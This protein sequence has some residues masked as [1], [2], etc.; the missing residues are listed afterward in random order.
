MTKGAEKKAV[1]RLEDVRLRFG[2]VEALRG[3]SLEVREGEILA[4]IGP[5]GAGKTCVFNCING[6]YKPHAG[7]IYYGDVEITKLRPDRIANMGIART[8]QNIQL[9]TGLSAVDNL[10]AGR[11]IRMRN[12]WIQG[13]LFYGLARKEEVENREFVEKI[14]DFLE[15]EAVRKEKIGAVPYG[16][17]KRVDLGRALAQEPRVLLL[18]EPMA[19]MNAEEKD[20]IARFVV[21]IFELRKIPIVL[22]E[23]DMGVVMDIADRIV[24]LNFG[25]VIAEGS[26]EEIKANPEVIEAYLGSEEAFEG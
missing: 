25:E 10:M 19:G 12:N 18:D 17:R 15:L 7:H 23:H 9:F 16:L 1:I 13:A 21:D 14:I 2:G 5:N 24:V 26:P 22:V 3:V 8:F 20:D 11:H 6:F 4:I